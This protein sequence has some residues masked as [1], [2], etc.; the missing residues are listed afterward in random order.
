MAQLKIS[1]CFG[2]QSEFKTILSIY[3]ICIIPQIP[4]PVTIVIGQILEM[5]WNIMF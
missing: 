1:Q 3:F 2:Y 4:G 5:E